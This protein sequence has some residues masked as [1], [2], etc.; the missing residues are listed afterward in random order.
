[1][2]ILEDAGELLATSQ[3]LQND[4][5]FNNNHQHSYRLCHWR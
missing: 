5:T 4:S 1:M 3:A 2:A